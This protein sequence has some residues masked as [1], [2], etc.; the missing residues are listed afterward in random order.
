MRSGQQ[1]TRRFEIDRG[2]LERRASSQPLRGDGGLACRDVQRA[3]GQMGAQ[4]RRHQLTGD[5]FRLGPDRNHQR[6]GSR[7]RANPMRPGNMRP[8]R[9]YRPDLDGTE[10]SARA[11]RA[12]R[13]SSNPSR[14]SGSW[15][16]VLRLRCRPRREQFGALVGSPPPAGID[17]PQRHVRQHDDG[18]AGG[19]SLQVS[20][21]PRHLTGAQTPQ[22]A[23]PAGRKSDTLLR[24][25]RCAPWSSKV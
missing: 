11:R 22:S 2:N 12:R 16:A 7:P 18:F 13:V 19:T 6:H 8:K 23:R 14:H 5:M 24:A 25:M 10:A 1:E 20:L 15:R 21:E 3:P 4:L 9:A 17:R